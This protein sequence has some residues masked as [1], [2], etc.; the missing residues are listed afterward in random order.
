MSFSKI[1]VSIVECF[2]NFQASHTISEFLSPVTNTLGSA[3]KSTTLKTFPQ[4]LFVHFGKFYIGE[5]WIPKKLDVEISGT[6]EILDLEFLRSQTI[7]INETVT[8]DETFT[9]NHELLVQLLEIGCDEMLAKQALMMFKNDFDSALSWVLNP[10]LPRDLEDNRNEASKPDILL[11]ESM[12]DL[13]FSH[14]QAVYALKK[15]S[16][17]VE[18]AI[19]YLFSHNEE[20]SSLINSQNLPKINIY[21]GIAHYQLI[22]IISHIG[23][24]TLCGHY[25]THIY[26]DDRWILFNDEKVTESKN[27]PFKFGYL[28]LYKRYLQ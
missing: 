7:P 28:Y 25:V 21:D 16:N 11:I 4:Y 17:N 24:S 5:D 15:T 10:D 1:N 12:M 2:E 13:G 27:P 14:D 26:K 6:D 9:L 3:V 8:S 22:S 20:I 19:D 18:R 23:S